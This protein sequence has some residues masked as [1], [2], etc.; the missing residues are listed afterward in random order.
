MTFSFYKLFCLYMMT[1]RKTNLAWKASQ[2]TPVRQ[3]VFQ[4][5]PVPPLRL[6][7]TVWALRRRPHNL[8][9]RWDGL[10]PQGP[11]VFAHLAN[12][13]AWPQLSRLA[14]EGTSPDDPG[15]A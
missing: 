14:D 4:I 10:R 8:V 11:R 3:I 12:V 5:K 13:I 7:L 2:D 1:I 9:D 6:D 15:A